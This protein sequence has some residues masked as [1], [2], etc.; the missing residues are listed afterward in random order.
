MALRPLTEIETKRLK[1]L[2]AESVDFALIQPTRTGLKKS[3]LDATGQ[4]RA[5]LR[6]QGIHDFEA[7]GQGANEHGVR[8]EAALLLPE[9]TIRS[10]VSLYRPRTKKGDP[11]IWFRKLPSF[12]EPDDI[13]AISTYDRGLYLLNVTRTD[14]D[15]VLDEQRRGPLWEIIDS[16]RIGTGAVALELLNRLRKIASSGPIRSVIEGRA[17]TAVGRTLETHLGI[18]INS[19]KKPDYKGIEIKSFRELNNRKTLFAKVPNWNMSK[20]K[21]SAEILDAFG[22]WRAGLRRLNCTVSTRTPPNSQGLSLELNHDFD[23]L[24]EVSKDPQFGAFATWPMEDLRSRLLMKHNETFWVSADGELV[25]GQE[26]FVFKSVLH[27][28]KPIPSQFD[29]LLEQGKITLDHLIK[30]NSRGRV[31]ERGPLFKISS[32]ALTMLFPPGKTYALP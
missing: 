24:N 11:R 23:V 30:R 2:I 32:D 28:R 14:F 21:S 5:F 9:K 18:D 15:H 1:R 27:T 10:E 16:I 29:F 13:L 17:D 12:A 25:N 31:I 22:Y 7:Q 6:T 3:I 26:Y 19:S 4:V 20:L 8:K